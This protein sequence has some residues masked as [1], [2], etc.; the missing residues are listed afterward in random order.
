MG[1][2]T[3][4]KVDGGGICFD[5]RRKHK[6]I[7]LFPVKGEDGVVRLGSR[8]IGDNSKSTDDLEK[9]GELYDQTL[10]EKPGE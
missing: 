9:K 7:Q 10:D 8:I 5:K 4:L 1:K 6:V 3:D 2:E